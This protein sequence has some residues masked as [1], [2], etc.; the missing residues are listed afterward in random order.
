MEID[1]QRILE[2]LK[3]RGED[4]TAHQAD[5]ELPEQVDTDEHSDL[6][7]RLGIDPTDLLGGGDLGGL[8]DKIGL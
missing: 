7:S 4:T 6:L 1:K 3:S 2:M 5:A 8:G